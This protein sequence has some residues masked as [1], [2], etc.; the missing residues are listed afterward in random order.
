MGQ[1]VI[2]APEGSKEDEI[3]I[4]GRGIASANS[5]PT[6]TEKISDNDRTETPK[7]ADESLPEPLFTAAP[8]HYSIGARMIYWISS[9]LLSFLLLFVVV[10]FAMVK[11][12]PSIVWVLS[13]WMQFKD[14]NRL[15]PFFAEE[16]RRKRLPTG[17]LKCD[18]GYYARR[19]GLECEEMKVETEDGFILTIQ[20]IVDPKDRETDL[21]SALI[22]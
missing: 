2:S 11:T 5:T 7:L 18:I 4:S 3:A 14:P 13:S 16:K 21:K 12:V 20:H 17:K 1:R 19:E 15:R 10:S 9:A 6:T 22:L 8:T